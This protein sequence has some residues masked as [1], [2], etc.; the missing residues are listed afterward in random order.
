MF[1]ILNLKLGINYGA[2][3]VLQAILGVSHQNDENQEHF[4]DPGELWPP[5]CEFLSQ[6]S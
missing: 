3:E 5:L 2:L 4:F 6:M 1:F